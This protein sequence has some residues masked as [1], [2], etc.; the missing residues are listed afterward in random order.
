MKTTVEIND[1]LMTEAKELARS[2]NT[3]LRNII[4][5][6]LRRMIDEAEEPKPKFK[7]RDG[8]VGGD[9]LVKER[10]WEEIRD[11]IYEGRGA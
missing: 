1:R 5:Q 6:G 2:R 11:L 4:E 8:S 10:S 7:L 9:G 3:T